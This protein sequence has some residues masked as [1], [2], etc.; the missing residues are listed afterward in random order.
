[1]LPP[2]A[3]GNNQQSTILDGQWKS[4]CGGGCAQCDQKGGISMSGGATQYGDNKYLH[5]DT[6]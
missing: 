6:I 2:A 3:E 5:D 4:G 1:M